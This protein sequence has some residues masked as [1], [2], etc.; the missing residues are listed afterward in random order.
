[1][2]H[3]SGSVPGFWFSQTM[4]L[5]FAP[6]GLAARACGPGEIAMIIAPTK[7]AIAAKV[8]VFLRYDCTPGRADARGWLIPMSFPVP[9]ALVGAAFPSAFG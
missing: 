5:M 3:T 9:D 2:S 4:G 8:M 6:Q 7:A 1:M